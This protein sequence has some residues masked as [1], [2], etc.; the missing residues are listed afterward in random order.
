MESKE[1][2][3]LLDPQQAID[4]GSSEGPSGRETPLTISSSDG[5]LVDNYDRESL[6]A[7]EDDGSEEY[8][9]DDSEGVNRWVINEQSKPRKIS[10]KKR[11]DNAIFENWLEENQRRLAR[12]S[13]STVENTDDQRPW[14]DGTNRKIIEKAR[15]YQIE[16]YERAKQ[17]NTIAVLDTGKWI[18]WFFMYA[19]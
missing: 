12:S 19:F 9:S 14:I 1:K 2:K 7:Q 8:H 5:T 10:E 6:D 16:L 17:Q 15:E 18:M 11:A 3:H 4:P 13:N